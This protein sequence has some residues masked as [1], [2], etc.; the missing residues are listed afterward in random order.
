MLQKNWLAVLG[1]LV[2]VGLAASPGQSGAGSAGTRSATFDSR[3]GDERAAGVTPGEDTAW[4][5]AVVFRSHG[6]RR[7]YIGSVARPKAPTV[8]LGLALETA[9]GTLPAGAGVGTEYEIWFLG[10]GRTAVAGFSPALRQICL[11]PDPAPRQAAAMEMEELAALLRTARAPEP[12][13]GLLPAAARVATMCRAFQP[14]LDLRELCGESSVILVGRV[15]GILRQAHSPI[16]SPSRNQH[17]VYVVQA[18]D[19]LKHTTAGPLL[20]L[21]KV[22]TSGGPLPWTEHSSNG[23]GYWQDDSPMLAVGNR[24]C[25]FLRSPLD[26]NSNNRAQKRGYVSGIF[27]D[28]NG[29]VSGPVGML[30]EY[31]ASNPRISKVLLRGGLALPAEHRG[32]QRDRWQFLREPQIVEVPEAQALAAI[33]AAV[34]AP[35]PDRRR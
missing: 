7:E 20:P 21:I 28:G 6:G 16:N 18:E 12:T 5:L 17:T 19:C 32:A 10:N 25:L 3:A 26:N 22:R 1:C 15:V 35:P 24:Y 4:G 2:G 33:R 30:D 27:S 13:S 34:R 23:I 14:P 9:G 8:A 29:V 11:G 31:Y